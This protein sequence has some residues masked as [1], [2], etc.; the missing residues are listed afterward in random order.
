MLLDSQINLQQFFEHGFAV[1]QLH[2]YIADNLLTYMR[3]QKWREPEPYTIGLPSPDIVDWSNSTPPLMFEEFW[4]KLA[5]HSYFS[6]FAV[7]NG[8]F[9]KFKL[10]AHRWHAEN[11]LGF[12]IDYHEALPINNIL[13]LSGD[14]WSESHGGELQVGKWQVDR[15]GF[16]MQETVEV[17]ASIPPIHGTLVTLFNG[18]PLF[19]HSVRPMTVKKEKYSFI[20]RLGYQENYAKA[21][22]STSM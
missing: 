9:S 20:C 18:S 11:G 3:A 10:S 1:T 12:H 14:T 21:R 8:E 7:Y 2:P 4:R 5:E 15:N 13:Y 17:L 6:Y 22:F 16:G 19:C